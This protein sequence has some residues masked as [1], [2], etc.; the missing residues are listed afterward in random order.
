MRYFDVRSNEFKPEKKQ[1]LK[2]L[3]VNFRLTTVINLHQTIKTIRKIKTIFIDHSSQS[4]I[5]K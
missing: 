1:F 2:N 3:L 4:K 5:Y